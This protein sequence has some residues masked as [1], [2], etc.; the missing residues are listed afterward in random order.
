MKLSRYLVIWAWLAG[1]MLLGVCLSFLPISHMTLV[2]LVLGLS[3]I[4][5]ILVGM[6]FMHLKFDPRFLTFVA[7][8][9]I[10]FALALA[11]ILLLDKPIL[12]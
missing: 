5:A 10:P 7:V 11:V 9:P 1:L 12:P 6:Y 2:L 8:I 4:K 3:A